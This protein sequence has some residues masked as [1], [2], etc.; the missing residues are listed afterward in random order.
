MSGAKPMATPGVSETK[1]E[2]DGYDDSPELVG[3]EATA[4]RGVATRLNYLA[5]DRPDL[6]FSAKE[7]SKKMAKP[8]AADWSKLKRLAR[9]LVGTPRML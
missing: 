9:Y 4:Y 7:I 2:T 6:Q 5:M 3:S 1:E 8:R